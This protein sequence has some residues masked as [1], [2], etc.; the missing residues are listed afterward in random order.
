MIATEKVKSN[1]LEGDIINDSAIGRDEKSTI[2]LGVMNSSNDC[3]AEPSTSNDLR[4]VS[5]SSDATDGLN[6][7]A[8]KR[9]R[10]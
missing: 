8:L 9:P 5:S 7:I 1:Q 2:E 10:L 4:N 3:S 6:S